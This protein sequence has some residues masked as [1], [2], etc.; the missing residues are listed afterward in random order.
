L[1]ADNVALDESY[2]RR[3]EAA[4]RLLDLHGPLRVVAIHTE[5]ATSGE[6]EVQGAGDSFRIDFQLA[7]L[8]GSPIQLYTLPD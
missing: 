2:P 7:P 3:A 6:V 4:R 8:A 5:S 1:F